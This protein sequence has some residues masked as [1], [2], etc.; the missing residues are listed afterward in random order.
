MKKLSLGK[1]GE[2]LLISSIVILIGVLSYTNMINTAF[3]KTVFRPFDEKSNAYLDNTLKKAI[4]TYAI[5]RGINGVISVVQNTRVDMSPAGI[6][7]SMAFG[8]ILDPVNDLVERFSWVMLVSTVAL[9]VQKIFLSLGTWL[10]LNILLSLSMV[11]LLIAIW[12]PHH[13]KDMVMGLGYKL[14]GISMVVWLCVP[15]ITIAGGKVYDLFLKDRYNTASQSLDLI[16]KEL[17]QTDVI[18][19]NPSKNNGE[20][21]LLDDVKSYYKEA[22]HSLNINARINDLKQKLSNYAEHTIN[23]IIVFLAQTV[24]LPLLF[25]WLFIRSC[26]F[27]FRFGNK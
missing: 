12:I 3:E 23:L 7:V 5:V 24:I 27:L 14:I 13:S 22:K 2:K 9:G 21:G 19:T 11:V 8:E 16:N 18:G 6:G 15:V 25:L 20:T 17:K 1:T 10:G 26:V 4:Y